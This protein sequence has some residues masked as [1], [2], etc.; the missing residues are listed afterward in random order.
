MKSTSWFCSAVSRCAD[1]VSF[2]VMPDS[3]TPSFLATYLATSTSNPDIVPS[4]DFSP[5]PGWSNL[6]PTVRVPPLPLSTSPA[7]EPD[8]AGALDAADDAAAGAEDAA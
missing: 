3:S 4:A 6:T 1:G 8:A 2:Q 7:V 5:R